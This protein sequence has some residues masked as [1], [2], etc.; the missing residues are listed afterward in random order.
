MLEANLE[1]CLTSYTLRLANW[2]S[3]VVY[4]ETNPEN[5]VDLV[6]LGATLKF[7]GPHRNCA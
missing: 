5:L 6:D 4:L 2:E 7:G 1:I 3:L